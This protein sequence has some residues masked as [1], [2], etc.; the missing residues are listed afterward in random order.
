MAE[1]VVTS[2]PCC[3]SPDDYFCVPSTQRPQARV[4]GYKWRPGAA[5][6]L[7]WSR[8]R[9]NR[10]AAPPPRRKSFV[11]SFPHEE[12]CPN[13]CAFS[14]C[15]C[16]RLL[17]SLIAHHQAGSVC[18]LPSIWS[19]MAR[20]HTFHYFAVGV[21]PGPNLPAHSGAQDIASYHRPLG[22]PTTPLARLLTML[23]G[24]LDIGAAAWARAPPD[25][26][27]LFASPCTTRSQ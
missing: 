18:I 7:S 26:R 4:D 14:G 21:R 16:G 20:P 11:C 12:W 19:V 9:R 5:A 15:K 8:E 2:T 23:I 25:R 6:P 13:L 3:G 1:G 27:E 17:R 24:A 22:D 10:Y